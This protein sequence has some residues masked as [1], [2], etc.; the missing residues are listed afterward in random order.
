MAGLLEPDSGH[1]RLAGSPVFGEGPVVPPESRS[2]GLVFQEPSLFPHLS[3]RENVLFAGDGPDA[4]R[5]FRQILAV[6]RLEGLEDRYP[7]EL[8]GGQQ[9]R[10]ALARALMQ[11]PRIL[12][13]DEPFSSLDTNMRE[14]LHRDVRRIQAAFGL[15]VV[16]VTHELR[17]AC[18][19]GDRI[20]VI[21]DGRIEQ[22]GD[23]LT[24]IRHP[25]TFDVA[26]FV[27]VRNLFEAIVLETGDGRAVVGIGG[28][29]LRAPLPS[30]VEIGQAVYVCVRPEDFAVSRL[31]EGHG[32]PGENSVSVTL[33]SRQLRGPT[34]TLAGEARGADSGLRL[35]IELPVRDYEAL[36]LGRQ[37]EV[38]ANVPPQAVHLIPARPSDRPSSTVTRCDDSASQVVL[39]AERRVT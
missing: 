5:R 22:V 35:E 34:I 2:V 24:V 6:T 25:A 36:D 13:L 9:Q 32:E 29:R 7:R 8:S 19:L 38:V 17:D 10:A 20:A 16:Y 12:L 30:G 31:P 14:R 1:L 18:T 28:L 33:H 23:P 3:V 26:R 11:R 21:G 15:C 27:G 4:S 39:T 37:S